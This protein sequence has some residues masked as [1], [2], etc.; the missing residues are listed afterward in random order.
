[1]TD[2]AADR[3]RLGEW[4]A[5]L[6]Q[7]A[8]QALTPDKRAW[9]Q[10]LEGRG[11]E[12]WAAEV[13]ARLGE[14]DAAREARA[15]R[16]AA[17]GEGRLTAL[18]APW[19]LDLVADKLDAVAAAAQALGAKPPRRP[20]LLATTMGGSVN[21]WAVDP[22]AAGH[23]LILI[24]VGLCMFCNLAAKAIA[25]VAPRTD[26]APG[27]FSFDL[28]PEVLRRSLDADREPSLRF[29]ELVRAYLL[30]GRPDA[31]R[32]SLPSAGHAPLHN[33]LLRAME[34]F[35]VAHEYGH[36]SAGH[37]DLPADPPPDLHRCEHEADI[38]ALAATARALHDEDT[39]PVNAL[40][41]AHLFLR[42]A[43]IVA[44]CLALLRG[45]DPA[46]AGGDTPTHPAAAKRIALLADLAGDI[47]GQERAEDARDLC[48]RYDIILDDF[49][50]AAEAQMGALRQMGAVP[51]GI[52]RP[53]GR[54]PQQGAWPAL[55]L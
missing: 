6:Q 22:G 15:A 19:A 12:A 42:T 17:A 27:R 11:G 48:R 18:D 43:G 47:L 3:R 39:D 34:M 20:P 8:W 2:A 54:A 29:A 51:H 52:W 1:M 40:V 35:L 9:R 28:D 44:R 14:D 49:A 32:R 36:V 24:P 26:V 23:T 25:R 16:I 41:G 50:A 30:Q 31:A 33:T 7:A 13:S 38:C 21:G 53:G 55:A 4:L 5:P 45:E 46:T 37:L 10:A